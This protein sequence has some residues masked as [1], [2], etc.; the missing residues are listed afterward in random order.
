VSNP[1]LSKALTAGGAIAPY[2]VVKFSAA[3]T[4]VQSA[5]ATDMHI[6][7][8]TDLAVASGERF[9]VSTHGIAWVEAGAAGTLGGPFTSDAQGRAVNAAPA[10]GVNNRIGGIFWDAPA[11][12]GDIVRVLLS[13]GLVQG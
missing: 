13:P 5:A 10:A 8:N 6:G 12:A 2:R 4:A 1:L 9:E 11:A 7:V 3:E